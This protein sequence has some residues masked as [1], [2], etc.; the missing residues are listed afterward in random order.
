M[1]LH[2]KLQN[3]Y[4]DDSCLQSSNDSS[5][6]LNNTYDFKF[7]LMIYGCLAGANSLFTLFRAFFFA[8][9]GIVAATS[10][11]KHLLRRIVTV[12][13]YFVNVILEI[14][15]RWKSISNLCRRNF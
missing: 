14:D 7:Y 13:H 1:S 9:G 2:Q 5:L 10:L 12:I 15:T 4:N 6:A 11:H 8:Y 3:L